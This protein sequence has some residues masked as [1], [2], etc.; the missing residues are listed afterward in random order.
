M[1][2]RVVVP[3]IDS[4][5]A[6][7]ALDYA[8]SHPPRE[9]LICVHAINP[10]PYVSDIGG[11][12]GPLM[13]D[14]KRTEAVQLMETIESY[15]SKE[16]CEL[17]TVIEK[18]RPRTVIIEYVQTHPVDEIIIGTHG[19]TGVTRVLIGSVSE[20]ILRESPVP[21]TVVPPTVSVPSTP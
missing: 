3:V 11:V 7:A 8:F 19:R 17:E 16:S 12:G 9:K 5:P 14:Q 6:W 10:T 21:V 18:G 13:L 20:A 1:K 2:D 4:P 15:A